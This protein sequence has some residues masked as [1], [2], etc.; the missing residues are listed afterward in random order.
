MTRQKHLVH[1]PPSRWR[2]LG[3]SVL[4]LMLTACA[5][6]PDYQRPAI[7]VGDTYKEMDRA[8]P[9]DGAQVNSGWVRAQP[10]DSLMPGDWWTLFNDPVLSGLMATLQTAN[11]DIAQAEAQYRQA[12]ALLQSTRSGL[13]PTLGSSAS[14]TRS[15]SGGGTAGGGDFGDGSFSPGSRVG[16]QYSVS[17]NVSWEPDVWGR[18]RRSVEASQAGLEAS[19]AD[20]AATRLS[21]QSTLAQTYFRLRVMDAEQRLL[22]QTVQAYERSL[23]MTQNRYEAGVAA[24]ADVE[25]SRTQLENTRTQLLALDWQRAQLEHAIA[26]LTGQA[27]SSFT[28]GSTTRAAAVPTIPVALPSQLLQRRPDVAAAERRTAEANARIGVAQAAWFPDLT[29]S[30]QAGFRSGQWAQWLTAPASFWSLGP[31]LALTIFDGGAREAQLQEARAGYDAQAAA[32]RQTVLTA[33]R[34]VED[35]LVQLH[36][37]GQEQVTQGRALAAA[38][39]SLR[40][41]QN[42]FEAGL[43]DYLSVVQVE[44]T[45]LST[46]RAALSLTA[47]RLVA[48]VQLIAALGGGWQQPAPESAA[49][50]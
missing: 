49:Q 48:S 43:I 47:D 20:V 46:E 6:G 3:I 2:S 21:M 5:M 40:L 23:Q 4:A 45:A 32:Y 26:V 38:R 28:L 14:A 22:A 50:P 37:L 15:G 33:L 17:G 44:T 1:F 41:T 8:Q 36:V 30:A 39:A 42:Q 34:E 12:Q 19:A 29:L 31:A 18:V 25:V 27:P 16:N 10:A 13:F 11:L 24:Q 9:M 7:D 35:Y